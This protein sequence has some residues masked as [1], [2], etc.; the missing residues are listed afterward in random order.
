VLSVAPALAEAIRRTHD[1][2][3]VSVLFNQ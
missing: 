3:S 1:G 2:Q